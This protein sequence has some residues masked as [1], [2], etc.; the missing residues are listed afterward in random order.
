[1][2]I[3]I[4]CSYHEKMRRS[5]DCRGSGER[6][7]NKISEWR[8]I[9]ILFDM[10]NGC[11]LR[12]TFCAIVSHLQS[13]IATA[14]RV[15]PGVG[16]RECRY[17][18]NPRLDGIFIHL[19]K[20]CGVNTSQQWSISDQVAPRPTPIVLTCFSVTCLACLG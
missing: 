8:I 17:S 6:V 19:T 15:K 3:E 7:E 11:S 18:L 2:Q 12:D 20:V 1:M 16:E 10:H 9:F 13:I 5:V 4:V 14:N